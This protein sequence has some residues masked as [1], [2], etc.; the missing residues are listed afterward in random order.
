MKSSDYAQTLTTVLGIVVMLTIT[1]LWLLVF[2]LLDNHVK[3]FPNAE[4]N[5][6]SHA[7]SVE[8]VAVPISPVIKAEQ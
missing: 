8:N 7:V 1:P 5:A 4:A 3:L 2:G 6:A